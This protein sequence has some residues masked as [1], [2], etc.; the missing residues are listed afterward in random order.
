M[1]SGYYDCKVV[2][3]MKI[4]KQFYL[5][6]NLIRP[7]YIFPYY[8]FIFIHP[9]HTIIKRNIACTKNYVKKCKK[10]F[11]ILKKHFHLW[12]GKKIIILGIFI[13]NRMDESF[14][15]FGEKLPQLN[16]I[17]MEFCEGNRMDIKK[18]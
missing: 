5:K 9:L 17:I 13:A 8:I 16:L 4:A 15:S 10:C 14:S 2:N 7:N 6:E 11:A 1:N 12:W 18:L 3:D